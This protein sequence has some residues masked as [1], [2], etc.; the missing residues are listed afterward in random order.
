MP[1]ELL[2]RYPLLQM[3]PPAQVQDWVAAGQLATFSVGETIFQENSPG[4]WAYLVLDGRVRVLRRSASERD[5]SLGMLGPGELFGEYAL[6]EPYL[7]TA[8]CRAGAA[9]RLLRLPLAR[10]RLLV[11]AEAGLAANLKNWLRLHTLLAY[12]RG[13]SFLGFLSA[14]SGLKFVD[15]L[16]SEPLRALRTVQADGVS[17]DRWFF[18]QS[19]QVQ[20]YASANQD[21]PP[22]AELGPGDHF[23]AGALA[24]VDNLPVVVTLAPTQCLSLARAVF[25][26]QDLAGARSG[27]QTRGGQT[28]HPFVWIGQREEAD[29]GVAALAMVARFHGLESDVDGLRRQIEVG[30]EGASLVQLQRAGA[31]LGLRCL[32]AQVDVQR[33]GQVRLPTIA[34]LRSRHY[35]VVCAVTEDHVVVGDP[36]TGVVRLSPAVFAQAY[37]GKVLVVLPPADVTADSVHKGVVS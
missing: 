16:E 8:S 22:L 12:L 24:G 31:A 20:L 23:G 10:L 3:L 9:C 36:A 13:Q 35:V 19:G 34:H 27:K 14:P 37:S 25:D 6:L 26:P 4:D 17:G 21:G 7:N 11:T 32:A 28:L 18:I 33:L 5:V 15:A 2:R 1:L 29:C 30:T